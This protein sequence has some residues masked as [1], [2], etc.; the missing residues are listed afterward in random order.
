MKTGKLR[1][2]ED[3]LIAF[4]CNGCKEYHGIRLEG[5]K[6]PI[7]SFNGDYEKPT[8]TPSILIR[9]GHYLLENK[10]ACWCTY[11]KEHSDNPAPFKCSVCHSFVTDGKIQYLNDCTHE[12]AGQTIEL[13]DEEE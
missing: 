12:L 6:T 3:G 11:N 2:L 7:W 13:P 10:G 1:I 9:S 5:N 8:F 4:Y